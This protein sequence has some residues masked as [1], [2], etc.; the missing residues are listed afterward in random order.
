MIDMVGLTCG[1]SELAKTNNFSIK[2][3]VAQFYLGMYFTS[4][5]DCLPSSSYTIH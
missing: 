1:V 2:L 4:S 3:P 5:Y